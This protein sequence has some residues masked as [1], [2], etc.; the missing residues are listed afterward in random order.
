MLIIYSINKVDF[1][2]KASAIIALLGFVAYLMSRGLK[3]VNKKSK[4]ES[5]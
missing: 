4:N 5:N 2:I 1:T 3:K